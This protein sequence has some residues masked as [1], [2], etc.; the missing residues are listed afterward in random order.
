VLNKI[1][2]VFS[3]SV[4]VAE[5]EKIPTVKEK[6]SIYDQPQTNWISKKALNQS[7][8]D[9]AMERTFLVDPI[10]K[11]SHDV[12]VMDAAVNE[13]QPYSLKLQSQGDSTLPPGQL[14]WYASFGFIG[15]NA[16]AILSQHWLVDKACTVPAK[17]VVRNWFDITVNDGFEVDEKILNELCE[18]D[19]RYH[20]PKKVTEFVRKGRVFGYRLAYFKVDSDDPNYYELPFNID[21][22]KPGSYRG[23]VQIDPYWVIGQLDSE[24]QGDPASLNFYEPTW[25]QVGALRIHKSHCVIFRTCDLPDVL[26][27]T[28]QFGGV[29]VPQMI[30]SRIYAAERLADEAPALALTKRTD[31][32]KVDSAQAIAQGVNFYD[33]IN[34]WI[35]NRSNF[36]I[37]IVD[38]ESED[39]VTNDTS[40]DGLKDNIMT[41][42]QLCCSVADVPAVK[43]LGV[44]P[45]G[46]NSTG[47]GEEA[48]YH[49]LIAGLQAGAV[50]D[51]VNRHHDLVIKSVIMPK[52]NIASFDTTI[53]WRP[54]DEMT[55][56][57]KAETNQLKAQTDVLLSQAGA[58]DGADIRKRII[59]D[60]DSGYNGIDEELPDDIFE[61]EEDL[62]S[63]SV[64]KVSA[65]DG[66]DI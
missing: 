19:E 10:V 41:Q 20:L 48:I 59:T 9:A 57:E 35:Y 4:E 17:D 65:E 12:G 52:F 44:S 64:Q 3:K 23:I 6:K 58:I 18:Q 40:L 63:V 13:G 16:C 2:K 39:V 32:Y 49:E 47:E 62:K 53:N 21:A 51:L 55:S 8:Y 56:K 7:E 36:G 5:E 14:G 11:Q 61:D 28:Y 25:W 34:D 46:L 27:P 54:L 33:K 31:I 66:R 42:Y 38:K 24:A 22:V 45:T 15:Y 50:T 60:E 29:P 37:K 1:K 26:K 30:A 43:L